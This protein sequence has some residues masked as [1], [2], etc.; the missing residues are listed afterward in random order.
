[1]A[2]NQYYPVVIVPGIG[3]SKVVETDAAG[4]TLRTVWPLHIDKDGLIDKLKGPFMKMLFFR[5][6]AGFSDALASAAHDA[7][8]GLATRPDG[9][10][11]RR[12]K[13]VTY[14]YPLS[15]CTADEK[16]YIY[17]MAPVQNLS[18]VIGEDNVFFFAYNSFA[19]PYQVAEELRD[20]VKMVKER[21]GSEKVNF[22]PLSLGG[23]M[24]TAYLDLYGANEV[25]RVVYFVPALQGTLTLADVFRKKVDPGRADAALGVVAGENAAAKLKP[26]LGM[27]PPDVLKNVT[28]KLLNTLIGDV[29][30]GSGAMWACLPPDVYDGLAAKYLSDAAHKPLKEETDRYHAAQV[31]LPQTLKGLEE[32]GIGI[33]ICTCYGRSLME[34]LENAG[35][36]SSDGVIDIF[37]ASLGAK[38]A[39]LGRKLSAA[40]I[41]SA[42]RLSPDGTLDASTG[43]FPNSTWYFRNQYH[44]SIAYND[45]ALTVALRALSDESFTGVDSDPALGQFH[46]KE[47]NRV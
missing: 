11:A 14:N 5:R 26:L 23:A 28:E 47:D 24:F 15:E 18:K 1:M 3:Q 19:R 31:S 27:L 40:E 30:S 29:L 25:H 45:T 22:L 43:V 7:L 41:G 46:E 39:P 42:A 36:I 4:N 9:S 37:S 2:D 44:D 13:A 21:T 20:F 32:K 6:D 12:L 10:M 33:Y 17:K 38:A 34:G 16:R 8:S 35:K